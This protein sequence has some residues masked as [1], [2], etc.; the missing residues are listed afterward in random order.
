MASEARV[1]TCSH[2]Y[3]WLLASPQALGC[4]VTPHLNGETPGQVWA[5]PL[6][7]VSL[8]SSCDVGEDSVVLFV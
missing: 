6:G 1:F 7:H 3:R 8:S 4:T 2:Q 5:P